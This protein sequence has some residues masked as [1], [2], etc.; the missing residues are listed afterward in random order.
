M[1]RNSHDGTV[2]STDRLT[3]VDRLAGK[4]TCSRRQGDGWITISIDDLPSELRQ[5][6][7]VNS[8]ERLPRSI[9]PIQN[10]AAG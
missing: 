10:R 4:V 7:Y 2:F 5:S 9:S 6:E 3:K 8:Y 1:S